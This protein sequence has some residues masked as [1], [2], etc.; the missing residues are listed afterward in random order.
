MSVSSICIL[1]SLVYLPVFDILRR[2]RSRLCIMSSPFFQNALGDF[3]QIG[4]GIVRI[5]GH[6]LI[7]VRNGGEVAYPGL[8]QGILGIY[9]VVQ[10]RCFGWALLAADILDVPLLVA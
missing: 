4:A 1:Q 5:Q 6:E 8:A 9:L 3:P 10:L 7:R 2:S